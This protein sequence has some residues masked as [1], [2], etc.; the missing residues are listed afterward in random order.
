MAALVGTYTS[1]IRWTVLL[2]LCDRA[3]DAGIYLSTSY[4][5]P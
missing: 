5:H 4:I 2:V 1:R 3:A